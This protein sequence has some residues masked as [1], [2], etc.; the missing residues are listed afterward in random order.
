MMNW[1]LLILHSSAYS[2]FLLRKGIQR[3][4]C[5]NRHTIVITRKTAEKYFGKEDAIGKT[6]GFN[7]NTEMYKITGVME[8]IPSNSHFHFDM[9]ASM[10]GWDA[11]QIRFM[12][13]W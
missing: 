10:V 5:C 3:Q 4:H 12:D 13:V 8:D 1:P 9:F 7:N 6:L 11:G 2:R